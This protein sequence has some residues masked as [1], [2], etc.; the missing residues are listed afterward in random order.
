MDIVYGSAIIAGALF[1]FSTATTFKTF[2][3][4]SISFK[5]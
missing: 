2:V 4:E 5:N 3:P 1:L